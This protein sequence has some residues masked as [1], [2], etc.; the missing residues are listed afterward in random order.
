MTNNLFDSTSWTVRFD[1]SCAG[2]T[3]TN[4]RFGRDFDGFYGPLLTNDAPIDLTGNVW[5][6]DGAPIAD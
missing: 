6:D 1:S 2:C 4:N 3:A 5:D